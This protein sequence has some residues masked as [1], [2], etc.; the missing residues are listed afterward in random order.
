MCCGSSRGSG[1]RRPPKFRQTKYI[2]Y[3]RLKLS[4]IIN[5]TLKHPNIG[6]YPSPNYQHGELVT[7]RH[8]VIGC[9]VAM[10]A[11][12]VGRCTA[13]AESHSQTPRHRCLLARIFTP[14]DTWHRS[15]HGLRPPAL[16][17]LPRPN[18]SYCLA[19]DRIYELVSQQGWA[20]ADQMLEWRRSVCQHTLIYLLTL[21]CSFVDFEVSPVAWNYVHGCVRLSLGCRACG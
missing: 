7:A 6:D 8:Y 21:S 4:P 3:K 18:A 20:E 14:L 12:L 11:A 10:H 17:A 5:F 15:N 16:G 13:G 2:Q 1:K 9:H 19:S